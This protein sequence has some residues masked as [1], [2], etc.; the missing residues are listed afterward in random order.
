MK[1]VL[2]GKIIGTHGIKGEVKVVSD[3]DFKEDRFQVGNVCYLKLNE[4]MF[5]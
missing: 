5:D 2:V 4:E 1:Y 3:S